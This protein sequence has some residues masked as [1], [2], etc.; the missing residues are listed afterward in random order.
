MPI[1]EREAVAAEFLRKALAA[2]PAGSRRNYDE[3]L[4]R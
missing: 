3:L 2:K 1:R 4:A